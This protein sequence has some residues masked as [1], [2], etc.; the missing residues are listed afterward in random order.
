MT[1]ALFAAHVAGPLEFS[2]GDIIVGLVILLAAA[3]ALPLLLGT[4]ALMLYRRRTPAQERNRRAA[5]ITFFKAFALGLLA[6]LLLGSMIGGISEL[7][8]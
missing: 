1:G 4:I 6:Q 8:G 7:I 5:R 3:L 2:T